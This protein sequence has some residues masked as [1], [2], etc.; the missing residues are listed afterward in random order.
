MKR[1]SARFLFIRTLSPRVLGVGNAL[2][3]GLM[4][5]ASFNLV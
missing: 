4:L 2:A 1:G 5:T 3:A